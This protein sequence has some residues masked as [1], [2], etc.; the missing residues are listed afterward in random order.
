LLGRSYQNAE[1]HASNEG[2]ENANKE[3]SLLEQF[4]ACQSGRGG[5]IGE[6]AEDGIVS[7]IYNYNFVTTHLPLFVYIF[8]DET[9]A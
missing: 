4:E 9:P 1:N 7:L 3:M 2:E 8:R 6:I 5:V